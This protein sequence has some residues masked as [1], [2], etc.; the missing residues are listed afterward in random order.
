MPK[1]LELH[2]I[3]DEDGIKAIQILG[4]AEEHPKGHSL[5]MKI[6]DL[7]LQFD[8]EIQKRIKNSNEGLDA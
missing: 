6:Q 1:N 8:R 3:V 5:Y 4:T 2:I 7:I